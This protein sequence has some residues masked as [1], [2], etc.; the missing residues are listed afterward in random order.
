MLTSIMEDGFTGRIQ[1]G[2]VCCHANQLSLYWHEVAPEAGSHGQCFPVRGLFPRCHTSCSS[3]PSYRATFKS[4]QLSGI[5]GLR[6][7][8][9]RT[10][11]VA[12]AT[13]WLD[14]PLR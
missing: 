3:T 13:P 14:H 10:E 1:T 8:D 9:P 2:M 7:K 5:E 4:I 12:A 11:M 6:V